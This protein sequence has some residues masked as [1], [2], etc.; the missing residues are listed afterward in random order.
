MHSA[1]PTLLAAALVAALAV[2]PLQ[3]A[4]AHGDLDEAALAE[5][6]L[7]LDDYKAEV[8]ELV[9]EV[10]PVV[11]A[12]DQGEDASAMAAA[13][14]EHWEEVGVHGAIET[15]A[16]ITYPSVWQAL[17]SLQQAVAGDDGAAV[18]RAGEG[19]G[20]ALWQGFGAVRLAAYQVT[21]GAAPVAAQGDEAPLSGPETVDQIIADLEAAVRAYDAGNLDQAERL[22]HDTYMTRFE[23][24]EGDLIESDP[25]LVSRLEKDF[26]ANLPLL[27]QRGADSAAVRKQLAA[28]TEQLETA[29]LLLE[30]AQRTRSEV[31]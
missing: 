20:A 9:A 8:E 31:F 12:Y 1:L 3:S 28:M 30:Q 21:S 25:D 5:F 29:S 10:G 6:Q 18:A 22:I 23:G 26:N 4:R 2:T 11:A 27:M 24:L 19:V 16:T 14:I 13:L 17:I 15:H 7:H